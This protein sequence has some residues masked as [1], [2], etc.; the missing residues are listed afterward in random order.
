M[1]LSTIFFAFSHPFCLAPFLKS[2][3]F[4]P[5]VHLF[6]SSLAITVCRVSRRQKFQNMTVMK[7]TKFK[8]YYRLNKTNIQKYDY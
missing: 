6:I 1:P 7:N 5:Q 4:S 3:I 2:T 8:K